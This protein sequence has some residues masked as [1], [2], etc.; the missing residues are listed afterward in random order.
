MPAA[1]TGGWIRADRAVALPTARSPAGTDR[2]REPRQILRVCVRLAASPVPSQRAERL[3]DPNGS[4]HRPG[5][6]RQ[7]PERDLDQR[8]DTEREDHRPDPN[9]A[10]EQPSRGQD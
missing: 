9:G 10:A 7:S 8:P 2:A 6:Y 1:H 5:G 4:L 3:A